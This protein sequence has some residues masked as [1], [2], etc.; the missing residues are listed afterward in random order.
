MELAII[1]EFAF[2]IVVVQQQAEPRPLPRQRMAQHGEIAVRIAEEQDEQIERVMT[3]GDDELRYNL[4]A[5]PG[6]HY[7]LG[8][9]FGGTVTPV[10]RSRRLGRSNFRI[11]G[12][13]PPHQKVRPG[14]YTD[15]IHV[16]VEF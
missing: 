16:T 7:V 2:R 10:T 6:H 11:Y 1:G 9:G 14:I 3:N 12:Y 13:V 5:D 4:Y 15:I 8:D